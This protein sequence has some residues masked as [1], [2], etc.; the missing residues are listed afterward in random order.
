MTIITKFDQIDCSAWDQ[1]V[2]NSPVSSWFQ[3]RE[4]YNFFDSLNFAESFVVAVQENDI[5]QGVTVGYIQCDGSLLKQR[6]SRRAII[7]GGPLLSAQI[8]KRQLTSMLLAVK[9]LLNTHHCIYIETRNLNDYSYWR[10]VFEKCGF[11]YVPHYNFHITSLVS[12]RK[13]TDPYGNRSSPIRWSSIETDP[14]PSA[15]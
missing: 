14:S 11:K 3:T 4:A 12:S 15:L 5:L 9:E 6:L 1:L 10:N 8:S 2:E 7:T 13:T